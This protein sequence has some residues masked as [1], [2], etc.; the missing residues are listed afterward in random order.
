M[1]CVHYLC[2]SVKYDIEAFATISPKILWK[3]VVKW[4]VATTTRY[5]IVILAAKIDTFIKFY[6]QYNCV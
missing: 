1:P 6:H 3:S 4:Q 2:A 5:R